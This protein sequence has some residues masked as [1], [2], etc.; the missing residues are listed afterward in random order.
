MNIVYAILVLGVLGAVFGF[1]LAYAS[2]IFAVKVDERQEEVLAA[3]PGANCGGC[4]FPGCGGYAAAV[5]EGRA[6]TNLCVA[7]GAD[8]AA[9]VSEIMGTS[10]GNVEKSVAFVRCSGINNTVKK[11]EFAGVSTCLAATMLPGKGPSECSFACFGL[12]DCVKVC[13][14]GALD[15]ID[16]VAKVNREKC[17]GCRACVS[18]CPKS[19]INMI[20]YSATITVPCNSLDKGPVVNKVCSAGCIACKLC[21]KVCPFDAIVVKDNLAVIDY[22]KCTA[23]GACVQKCPRKLIKNLNPASN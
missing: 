8:C 17:V 11:Y 2:K 15:L 10:A 12:G 3:L 16:G 18:A 22:T 13:Q 9:K 1:V 4:G 6:A 5:V 23:C 7:G 21:E 20:P 14:F 19:I